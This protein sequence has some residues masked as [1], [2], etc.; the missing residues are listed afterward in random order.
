M[1]KVQIIMA[2]YCGEA[3]LRQQLDSIL[4]LQE[5]NWSLLICDDG[6]TDNTLSI[7]KEYN[8]KM[9]NRI[10]IHQNETNL[11]VTKN[12]LSALMTCVKKEKSD[13]YMFCDQD[14]VWFAGRLSI[15]LKRI[16]KME[17]TYGKECPLLVFSDA[18]VTDEKL[19]IKQPSYH[20]TQRLNVKK[21]DLG[22]LLMENKCSGCMMLFNYALASKVR[23][24][25]N[26]A[27]FHD[28]WI[29]L[30]ASA[31]GHIGYIKEPT[32]FYRQH[33]KNL[34]GSTTRLDYIKNSITQIQ[35]QKKALFLTQIQAAEFLK[36]YQREL[37]KEKRIKI[38]VFSLLSQRSPLERRIR[39]F[40]FHFLKSTILQNI[41]VFLLI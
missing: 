14:D 1:S 41:G 37:P 29:A 11:G 13:Y 35:K 9:P 15:M 30:I 36:I 20:K 33:K 18:I 25:P 5:K 19:N 16:K 22:H 23:V 7:L 40:K 39:I 24:L 4:T 2:S 12:F 6:S 31:F 38:K 34:V 17:K 8:E 28:W 21:T 27:R 32:L 3:Y 10:Q 26:N